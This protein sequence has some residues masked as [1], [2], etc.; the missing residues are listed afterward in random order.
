ALLRFLS[1]TLASPA[2]ASTSQ[3]KA[4]VMIQYQVLLL[5]PHLSKHNPV[6]KQPH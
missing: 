2:V 4:A 5:S 3:R 1:P 6:V